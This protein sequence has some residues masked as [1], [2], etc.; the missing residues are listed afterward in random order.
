[1]SEARGRTEVS[2]VVAAIGGAIV[3]HDALDGDAMAGEEGQRPG[4]EGAGAL[5][6][7]VGQ[8][9]GVGEAGSIV[10]ADMDQ[11]PAD[12]LLLAAAIAGDA[13]ADAVDP[14]EL[15]GVDVD[16]FARGR[17]LV[18]D[19]RRLGIERRK[20]AEAEPPEHGANGRE[21]HGEL[22][23]NLR[24]AHALTPEPL[25]LGDGLVSQAMGASGRRRAPVLKHLL[26]ARPKASQPLVGGPLRH[27]GSRGGLG[28]AP[29]FDHDA[30]HQKGSTM[31]RHA[32]ILVGVHPGLRLRAGWLRNPSLAATLRMNNLH[33]FDS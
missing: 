18:T 8:D 19:Y 31:D 10:D 1:M 9:L 6:L 32:G 21:R 33:S 30:V 15:L 16:Q 28:D 29:A 25:D 3:G 5:F 13:V 24:P 7:L 2:E 14:A 12:A 22:A 27:A 23:G 11:V 4:E 20:S 17:P 26:A